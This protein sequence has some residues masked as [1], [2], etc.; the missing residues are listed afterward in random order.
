M[1]HYTT[2]GFG[3]DL[4]ASIPTVLGTSV[5][6]LRQDEIRLQGRSEEVLARLHG[7]A[8]T[9]LTE[10]PQDSR[11][12]ISIYVGLDLLLRVES[13]LTSLLPPGFVLL[14]SAAS[15]IKGVAQQ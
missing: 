6:L 9:P 14:I 2:N 5:A 8:T 4:E 13:A 1:K 15:R 12:R 10:V 11:A 3:Q 7:I